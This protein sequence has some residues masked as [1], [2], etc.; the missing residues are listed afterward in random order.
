MNL[1]LY[2]KCQPCEGVEKAAQTGNSTGEGSEVKASVI[3]VSD[4][5]ASVCAGWRTRRG[6]G[7]NLERKRGDNMGVMSRGS[8]LERW[9]S[10]WSPEETSELE[11]PRGK[12]KLTGG[13]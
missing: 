3:W 2:E 6:A 1:A 12:L 11:R 5:K 10:R 4:R 8:G 13:H 7:L 9:P